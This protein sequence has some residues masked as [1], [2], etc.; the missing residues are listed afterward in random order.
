MFS[1]VFV[2]LAERGEFVLPIMYALLPNKTTETY[3]RMM[4]LICRR[5]P[6]FNPQIISTDFELAVMRAFSTKFPISVV[7]GCFF[8]LI[9][10]IKRKV[11]EEGLMR[12]YNSDPDSALHVRIPR[13]YFL[14]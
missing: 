1:Q 11:S 14:S 8:Y 10:N 13:V 3:G 2:I 4:Q 7:H 12:N 5:F 6:N 9:K